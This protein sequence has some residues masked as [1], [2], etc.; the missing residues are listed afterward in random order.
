MLDSTSPITLPGVPGVQ[1]YADLDDPRRVHVVPLRPGI[2]RGD[3]GRPELSL[4]VYGRGGSVAGGQL[5]VSVE[6]ALRPDQERAVHAALDRP[7]EPVTLAP[8]DWLAGQVTLTIAGR[9]TG[10]QA[11]LIG[12]NR[13]SLLVPLDGATAEALARD[14]PRAA[15]EAT[16]RYDVELVA[17]TRR[18]AEARADTAASQRRIA[19]SATG[20]A[21]LELTITGPLAP[22]P[23]VLAGTLKVVNL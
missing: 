1:A 8:P 18:H 9:D 10:G 6:L 3:D 15:A 22:D 16:V 20:P 14:W 4:L 21:S 17:G 23:T 13:C 19:V 2:A 12:G 7:D 5:T 11:S